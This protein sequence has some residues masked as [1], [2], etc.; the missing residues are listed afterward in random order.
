MTKPPDRTGDQ[1]RRSCAAL[2]IG[3]RREAARCAGVG[4]GD[5]PTSTSPAR[6]PVRSGTARRPALQAA[7]PNREP[8]LPSAGRWITS[9]SSEL[10]CVGQ[11]HH[12]EERPQRALHRSE[13]RSVV[14]SQWH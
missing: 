12:I 5:E 3:G 13:K 1:K 9:W 10:L 4:S 14:P 2:T 8:E 6:L 7:P 11:G